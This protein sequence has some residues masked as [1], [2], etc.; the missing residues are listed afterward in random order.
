MNSLPPVVINGTNIK[1]VDRVKNKRDSCSSVITIPSFTVTVQPK[2]IT[3]SPA[4]KK[5]PTRLDI[6]STTYCSLA[7]I[8][9][10]TSQWL[11]NNQYTWIWREQSDW[12]QNLVLPTTIDTWN[13]LMFGNLKVHL[14]TIFYFPLNNIFLVSSFLSMNQF[15]FSPSQ[16]PVS[17]L[18]SPHCFIYLRH[19]TWYYHKVV[20]KEAKMQSFKELWHGNYEQ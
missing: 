9:F 13:Q 1:Y 19:L 8:Y 16:I 3:K 5:A 7:T 4:Y 15:N 10:I 6:W 11:V 20:L 14:E 2:S 12:I 18:T 17:T